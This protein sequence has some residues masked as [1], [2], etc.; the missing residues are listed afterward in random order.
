MAVGRAYVPV[1][2]AEKRELPSGYDSVYV[3]TPRPEDGSEA[4]A[5]DKYSHTYAVFDS[6]QVLPR[7]V[8][9]FTYDASERQ[10]RAP[11]NPINL[12]DIKVRG[13]RR[14]AYGIAAS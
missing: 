11:I 3:H 13:S 8:V 2:P 1:D 12:M 9:H 14:G 4:S 7:Y 10:H 5:A 6:A